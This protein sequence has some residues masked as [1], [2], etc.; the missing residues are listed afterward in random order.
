MYIT[1]DFNLNERY[2]DVGLS[3]EGKQFVIKFTPVGW[4]ET[5]V[6]TAAER[7]FKGMTEADAEADPEKVIMALLPT[8]GAVTVD[9]NLEY[10]EIIVPESPDEPIIRVAKRIP[11]PLWIEQVKDEE[12]RKF[13]ILKLPPQIMQDY[14]VASMRMES[15]L[16]LEK[17]N[18]SVNSS[19]AL[20]TSPQGSEVTD[21]VRSLTPV[22]SA[23]ETEKALLDMDRQLSQIGSS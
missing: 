13:W 9:W 23:D 20:K 4:C 19:D 14:F 15:E 5:K 22:P 8:I 10:E 3:S 6:A 7:A 17:L 16:P 12:K 2:A 1:R 21:L 18:A 11:H